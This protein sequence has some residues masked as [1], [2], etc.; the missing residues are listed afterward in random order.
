MSTVWKGVDGGTKWRAGTKETEVI[1]WMNGVKV[2]LG[3]ERLR[4]NARMIG[5]SGE[6]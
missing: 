1:G 2:A 3:C 5:K 4:V 6:P